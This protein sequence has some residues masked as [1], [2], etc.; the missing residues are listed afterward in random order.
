MAL[1]MCVRYN[2]INGSYC[3]LGG[4]C[5][6]KDTPKISSLDIKCFRGLKNLKLDDLS[7]INIFVGG[8][9]S[10]KTSVLELLKLMSA[11]YDVTMLKNVALQRMSDSSKRRK[12]IVEYIKNMMFKY[13]DETGVTEYEINAGITFYNCKKNTLVIKARVNEYFDEKDQ[14]DK[15][16]YIEYLQDEY[17][18]NPKSY[19]IDNDGTVH[20][21]DDNK[22]NAV[23][24]ISGNKHRPYHVQYMYITSDDYSTYI[25]MMSERIISKGKDEILSIVRSFDGSISDINVLN[26]EIYLRDE[27]RGISLPLYAYGAGMQK[28]VFMSIAVAYCRGGVIL[29]DEVDN[30]LNISAFRN[31][32][33]W[34]IKACIDNNVQAFITT[35]SAEA[36]DEI[37]SISQDNYAKDDILRVITLR[38]NPETGDSIAKINTGSQAYEFRSDYRMELRI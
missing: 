1:H 13:S 7:N 36:L 4:G 30:A 10:G 33:S 27:K 38:K 16:L 26:D 31:V 6:V 24:N 22:I 29:I 15:S 2:M 34:F 20:N 11:Q 17:I 21:I 37:I 32:F 8:N 18:D 25:K 5:K 28:A 9:N 35:H 3:V 14:L 23:G 12:N 19:I